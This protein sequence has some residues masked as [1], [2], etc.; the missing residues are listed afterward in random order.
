MTTRTHKSASART[1]KIIELRRNNPCMTMQWIADRVG[2]SRERIRQVLS[3]AGLR[4][5]STCINIF[6]YCVHCGKPSKREF[7]SRQCKKEHNRVSVACFNCGT[8]INRKIV[9]IT[10]SKRHFCTRGCFND[11]RR[12][13]PKQLRTD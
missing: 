12:A 6:F 7:C 5:W 13:H 9:E 11:W 4:T 2:V 1:E 3:A 8:I 10:R